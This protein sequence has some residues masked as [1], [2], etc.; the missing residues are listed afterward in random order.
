MALPG[1]PRGHQH[2]GMPARSAGLLLYRTTTTGLDVLLAHPGGPFWARKDEGVWS[3]PKGEYDEGD[4][5][6][7]AARREFGEETGLSLPPGRPRPLGEV[8]QRSGKRVTAWAL[9]GDLDL[10]GAASNTFEMEWPRGS[11]RLV[12]FPEVDRIEW[13]PLE[14][15]FVKIAAALIRPGPTRRPDPIRCL[16]V[17]DPLRRAP[18]TKSLITGPNSSD[19]TG[20]ARGRLGEQCGGIGYVTT[21]RGWWSPWLPSRSWG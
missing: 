1:A 8:T 20:T 13:L 7:A 17:P 14:T 11:G 16:A 3:V 4:D 9:E 5:P 21:S 12:A 6:L 10:T 18:K 19:T 15:A 2:R